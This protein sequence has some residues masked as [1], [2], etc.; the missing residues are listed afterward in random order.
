MQSTHLI[1]NENDNVAIALKHFRKG[2]ILSLQDNEIKIIEDIPKGHKIA[3]QPMPELQHVVKYG[4]PIGHAKK[5][6]QVGEWVH[7]HN[8]QTNLEGTLQY[9]YQ[10]SL[11]SIEIGRASCRKREKH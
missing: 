9:T 3:I 11:E 2:D 10:P 7:T 5:S 4:Y 8:V 6:I 1:L